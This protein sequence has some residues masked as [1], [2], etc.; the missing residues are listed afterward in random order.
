M[1]LDTRLA[2][3]PDVNFFLKQMMNFNV[4]KVL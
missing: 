2:F 3:C 4:N 1:D